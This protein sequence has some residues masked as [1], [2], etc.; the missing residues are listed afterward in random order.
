MVWEDNI[1]V[2]EGIIPIHLLNP[3]YAVHLLLAAGLGTR[4]R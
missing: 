3:I 4:W 2:G 1:D